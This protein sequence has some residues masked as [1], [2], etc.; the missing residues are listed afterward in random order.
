MSHYAVSD[1]KFATTALSLSPISLPCPLPT[2]SPQSLYLAECTLL[3]ASAWRV[4][5]T[6]SAISNLRPLLFVSSAQSGPSPQNRRERNPVICLSHWL[7]FFFFFTGC[8]QPG[9]PS[10][11]A[12]VPHLQPALK[13][14]HYRGL[15]R[16][17]VSPRLNVGLLPPK[18]LLNTQIPNEPISTPYHPQFH[19]NKQT[20]KTNISCSLPSIVRAARPSLHLSLSLSLSLPLPHTHKLSNS[21]DTFMLV[22]NRT[23]LPAIPIA[24]FSFRPHLVSPAL[25]SP[26]G[27]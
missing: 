24:W 25:D 26:S 6:V 27:H 12:L 22:H 10:R 16:S 23:P 3:Q 2:P 18:T 7:F 8:R 21:P 11:V 9:N 19:L 13:S 1:H 5:R 20:N 17:P 4:A 15:S 14:T